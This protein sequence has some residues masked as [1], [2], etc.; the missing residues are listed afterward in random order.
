MPARKRGSASDGTWAAVAQAR[1][2]SEV[3]KKREL[4]AHCQAVWSLGFDARFWPM[5]ISLADLRTPMRPQ[6]RKERFMESLKI[7]IVRLVAAG[8]LGCGGFTHGK[9]AAER[10]IAH[11]HD[12]YNEG[13]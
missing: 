2:A 9:P 4:G 12:L 8:L 1:L 3:S 13:K 11:F 6:T 10:A 5:V 7:C